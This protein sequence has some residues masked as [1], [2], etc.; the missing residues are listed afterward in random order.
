MLTR[1]G[2]EVRAVRIAA[3]FEGLAGLVIPG[4][5]STTMLRLL[6]RDGMDEALRAYAAQ[7]PCFGTCAG[8]I[9]LARSVTPAQSSLGLIDIDVMRNAYGRQRESAILCGPCQLP[10]GE[11]E[12]VFIRAPRFTRV[13]HKVETLATRDG[14]AVLVRQGHYLAASFHPELSEDPRVHDAF[15]EML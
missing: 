7:R 10:G 1:R 5:E 11:L 6:E 13:G 8:A 9:L 14:E 4:G 15:L 12:M 3:D 2:A